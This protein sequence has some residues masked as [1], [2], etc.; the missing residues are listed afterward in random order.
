MKINEYS[1]VLTIAISFLLAACTSQDTTSSSV[2]DLSNENVRMV[3][4]S[5]LAGRQAGDIDAVSEVLDPSVDQLTSRAEWRHGLEATT[6]GMTRSSIMNPGDRSIE[7]ESV[8]FLR[9]DVALAD[10][11]YIIKGTDGPDRILWSSFTLVKNSDGM[12]LITSIRNQE[13]TN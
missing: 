10:A 5:Y 9:P 4:H 6:A 2:S 3:L 7:V 8:R 13:P 12:W 1:F 11:R